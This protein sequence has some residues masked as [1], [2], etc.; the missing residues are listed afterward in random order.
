[1]FFLKRGKYLNIK[2]FIYKYIYSYAILENWEWRLF[3]GDESE[4]MVSLNKDK[5]M[6]KKWQHNENFHLGL[7]ENFHLSLDENKVV[8]QRLK[9]QKNKKKP[10]EASVFHIT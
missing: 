3:I 1:M 2:Q 7:D 10:V 8:C 4:Q 5:V 9:V 6:W